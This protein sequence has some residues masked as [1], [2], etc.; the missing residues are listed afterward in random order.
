MKYCLVISAEDQ[1]IAIYD[2][3]IVGAGII[4][5]AH[6]YVA[7]RQGK[8]VVVFD[9]DAQPNGAS[10]RNFGFVT[11]TG[12]SAGDCWNKARRTRDIWRE[13]AK[14][15]EIEVL[16]RGMVL[17]A[18]QGHAETLIDAFLQTEMGRDC[19]KLTR[20]AA[21]DLVPPLKSEA[22]D[23]A[24]YSPHEIRVESRLAIPKLVNY[25]ASHLN[26]DFHWSTNVRKVE[27]T[28]I[29]TSN[30]VTEAE[31]IIVCP[32]DDF[33]GLFA[34]RLKQY[35]LKRCKLQMLRV[36]PSQAVKFG[37]TVLSELSLVRSAGY[38]GLAGLS[39]L[40]QQLDTEMPNQRVNDIH[41]IVAQSADGSLVVG[42]S[43][44][45]S[46]TPDPFSSVE[47]DDYIMSELDRVL[48]LP[49]RKVTARWLGTYGSSPGRWRITDKP[50]DNI[51]VVIVTSGCGAS[52]CFAIAEETINELY[53]G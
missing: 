49:E 6:A 14:A 19:T 44:H 17:A 52:T 38:E 3:A 7:A 25:L 34:D 27:Q 32:G 30:G 13:V 24:L 31:T 18:R 46:S 41:L 8:R 47:V 12:Q 5:L 9:R 16:Q 29:T 36:A 40:K 21:Q 42:D 20:Q 15:A 53:S 48:N 23:F 11:I 26:V 51:R 45:Y 4:G 43:H 50:A 37:S 22:T 2:I 10:I 1:V 35:D 39:A 28:K 33:T